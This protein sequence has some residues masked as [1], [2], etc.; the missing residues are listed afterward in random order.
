MAFPS[1]VFA[2]IAST[3]FFRNFRNSLGFNV[4]SG[5][6]NLNVISSL[7]APRTLS[8]T[9][10]SSGNAAKNSRVVFGLP[11]NKDFTTLLSS[12]LNCPPGSV[13]SI[14]PTEPLP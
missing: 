5:V 4:P 3:L 8:I 9:A 2:E 1:L 7:T 11:S 10:L 12:I 14:F 13:A 6:E